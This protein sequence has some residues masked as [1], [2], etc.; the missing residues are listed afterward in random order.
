[1]AILHEAVVTI[2]DFNIHPELSNDPTI[3]KQLTDLVGAYAVIARCVINDSQLN[4]SVVDVG[5]SVDLV[6][7]WSQDDAGVPNRTLPHLETASL[8]SVNFVSN[9]RHHVC[10]SPPCGQTTLTMYGRDVRIGS[11]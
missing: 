7:F 8:H 9:S 11:Q 2:A 3:T 10:A 4:V 6:A 5:L 1:V